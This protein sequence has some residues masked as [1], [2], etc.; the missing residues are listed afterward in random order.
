MCCVMKEVFDPILVKVP[1]QYGKLL[2][3]IA[4]RKFQ[5][6]FPFKNMATSKE[7]WSI[8]IDISSYGSWELETLLWRIIFRRKCILFS[9]SFRYLYP[10]LYIPIMYHLI[11]FPNEPL[12]T[13]FIP[14]ICKYHIYILKAES[15][16]SYAIALYLV[17]LRKLK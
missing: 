5:V 10:L 12:Y 11:S 7:S 8:I 15:Y 3:G 6:F 17:H 4:W 16:A 1:L 9:Y 14:L 2:I 13:S